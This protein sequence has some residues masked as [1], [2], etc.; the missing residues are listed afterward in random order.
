[1]HCGEDETLSGYEIIFADEDS[2]YQPYGGTV[3]W[4]GKSLDFELLSGDLLSGEQ[5]SSV[6]GDCYWMDTDESESIAFYEF[7]N[8][9]IQIEISLSGAIKRVNVTQ[10]PLMAEPEQRASYKVDKPWP[11]QF[12]A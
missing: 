8:Y 5:P 12:D 4:L 10:Q 7:P 6:F 3:S 2:E 1:M 9:E 11:P